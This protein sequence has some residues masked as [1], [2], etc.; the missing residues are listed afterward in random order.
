MLSSRWLVVILVAG[1]GGG[2]G[3]GGDDD[4]PVDAAVEG[5]DASGSSTDAASPA[6]DLV[7]DGPYTEQE[8]VIE[9]QTFDEADC[10]LFEG[11]I[12]APGTR[13]LLRLPMRVIN[14]G[15][16]AL[17]LGAPADGDPWQY[18]ACHDHYHFGFA[19]Y[20]LLDGDDNTVAT[21]SYSAFC[22]FDSEQ[23][24]GDASPTAV[25][26]DC[27]ALEPK[28]I[29]VG[30]AHVQ[31]GELPCQWI[32]ITD[33]APGDYDVR[34]TVNDDRVAAES[35]FDNNSVDVPVTIPE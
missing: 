1:C 6:P 33:V 14:Q 28:G 32:D 11:C 29:S 26:E 21:T 23:V 24:D 7:V 27:S 5:I 31:D 12:G 10:A 19:T 9:E 3:G 22:I 18:S 15:D 16:A 2:G 20:A 35:D 4:G 25:Y 17:E 30:W 8:L 13:T 34:L